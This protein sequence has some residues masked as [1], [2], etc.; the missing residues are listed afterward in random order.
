M[1]HEVVLTEDAER[2]LEE[3]YRYIAEFDSQKNADH[4]LDQL[5]ETTERLA[6]SPE[7]GSIPRE[8]QSLGIQ[9]YR[10]VFFKPYRLIYRPG[11]KR[12]VVYLIMDGRRDLQTLLTRRLLGS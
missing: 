10:Q 6:T 2:D 11:G 3:I 4:V 8:L 1:R 5:I 9:D 7:R 12:V